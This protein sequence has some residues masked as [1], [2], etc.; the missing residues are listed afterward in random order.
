MAAGVLGEINSTRG[1]SLTRAPARLRQPE[2]GMRLVVRGVPKGVL[3][4][5]SA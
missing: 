5:H 2:P 4:T 1:L 3:R